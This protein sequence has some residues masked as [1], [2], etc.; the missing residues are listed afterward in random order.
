MSNITTSAGSNGGQ[1]M[2]VSQN[3]YTKSYTKTNAQN[4]ENLMNSL[5][6]VKINSLNPNSTQDGQQHGQMQ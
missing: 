2:T 6:V 3:P 4:N 1:S 5:M